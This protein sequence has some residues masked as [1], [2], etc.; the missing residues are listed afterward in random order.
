M[1]EVFLLSPMRGV[2]SLFA[3]CRVVP[4]KTN[5][6]CIVRNL[7][8]LIIH[9]GNCN[10]GFTII[11]KLNH[12]CLNFDESGFHSIESTDA[13]RNKSS[14]GEACVAPDSN[15]NNNNNSG[16]DV[17]QQYREWKE[18]MVAA[19]AARDRAEQEKQVRNMRMTLFC[20][21]YVL[22][23]HNYIHV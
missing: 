11:P 2:V 13:E 12:L 1:V 8:T 6:N 19:T 16:V 21:V 5:C 17:N 9:V 10:V 3:M 23:Q 15:N 22:Q 14:L 18:M 4:I 7:S 20:S